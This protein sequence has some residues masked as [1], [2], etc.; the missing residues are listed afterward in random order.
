[1][2]PPRHLEVE[3]T[4]LPTE[5]SGRRAPIFTGFRSRLR[6]AGRD[7]EVVH[8]LARRDFLFPG[9]R[10][11]TFIGFSTPAPLQDQIHPGDTV[12]II[13]G[14]RLIGTALVRQ[15]LGPEA[16]PAPIGTSS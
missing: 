1:V 5:I 8:D 10:A 4:L 12:Q 16:P 7:R 6:Q 9:Q 2:T 13:E 15:V 11:V 3:L 14:E